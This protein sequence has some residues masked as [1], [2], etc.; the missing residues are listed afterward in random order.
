MA[1]STTNKKKATTTEVAE[2]GIYIKGAR[3]HNLKNVSVSIPRNQLVVVTGV[4]G[5]GKSSLTIDTLFAEGQRRYAESLSAYARQF[6][7]RMNKPDVDYIKGLCPAI[8]IEQKVITRTPRSTV[9]SMTEIYDYLRLLYARTGK[10]ISPISG[11][12]VKKDDVKDVIQAIRVQAAGSKVLI[13]VPFKQH[14]NR[15]PLEELNILLQKGF[16][17]MAIAD[18]TGKL[19]PKRIEELMEEG[20]ADLPDA[21]YL[22]IDRLVVKEFD[23]D[24]LHR[25]SDSVSTA[26]YEGEGTL[27]VQIN[28]T[29]T[30]HFSNKFE[31]D[32]LTFEEP[33]PNLFSFNN[34]FGACPVCEGFSQVLGIDPDL[35]IPNKQLSVYEGAV[36]P[37][38]GEKL[39]WWREQ[40]VKGARSNNFP[41]HKPIIDLT[42]EQ[43]QQLWEGTTH[44]Q[45]IADFFKEV[46][47][48]LYKVQY[49]VLLSRYRG[50]TQC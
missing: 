39:G 19:A 46:E 29:T 21:T 42:E 48:N 44:A 9:G 6:M 8:A 26:F 43:Y 31:L 33:V 17:R 3:V 16:S 41:I 18:E 20:V 7:Q 34:P 10:T 1:T 22:L 30:L 12:E 2:S 13:L 15:K 5:S 47:Q 14:R 27:Q 35:V 23:E 37:W 32:G 25:I 38:K 36:A 45:G 49:R 40:F 28:D 4:S 24:D 50:R 11:R